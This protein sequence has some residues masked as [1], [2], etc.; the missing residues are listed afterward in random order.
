MKN[1]KCFYFYEQCTGFLEKILNV[2][3]IEEC[4]QTNKLKGYCLDTEKTLDEM[5]YTIISEKEA[6]KLVN[7]I[8]IIGLLKNYQA[9]IIYRLD[10]NGWE[11]D[12][13]DLRFDE[14]IHYYKI[15]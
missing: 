8:M 12:I 6:K 15:V 3:D 7:D 9:C 5:L 14:I 1:S 4:Y 13:G 2:Y 10:S 11:T